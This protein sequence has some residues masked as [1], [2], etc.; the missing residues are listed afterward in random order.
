M[1]K[2]LVFID[3]NDKGIGLSLDEIST[4]EH[5]TDSIIIET[6]GGKIY[7]TCL[8]GIRDIKDK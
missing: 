4:I 8:I 5:G 7:K 3:I 1:K 6:I 2:V